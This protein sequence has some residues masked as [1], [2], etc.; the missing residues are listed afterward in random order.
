MVDAKH[1]RDLLAV[2][3]MAEMTDSVMTLLD[4]VAKLNERNYLL[5]EQNSQLTEKLP[6]FRRALSGH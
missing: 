4:Q 2:N 6:A 1:I 5:T 3:S